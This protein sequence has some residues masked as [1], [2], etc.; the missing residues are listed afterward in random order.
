PA[1]A[2][3]DHRDLA[4]GMQRPE[5]SR[6]QRVVVED[7]K[8]SEPDSFRIVVAVKREMPAAMTGAAVDGH[9]DLVDGPGI[10]DCDHE[11]V[12]NA[13]A[14]FEGLQTYHDRTKH[15]NH[16]PFLGPV[17]SL[18]ATSHGPYARRTRHRCGR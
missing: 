7:P 10:P 9:V 11:D 17:R 15:R 14:D 13:P 8:R 12:S 2:V 5:G 18:S 1:L 3:R 4:V 6:R 16:F